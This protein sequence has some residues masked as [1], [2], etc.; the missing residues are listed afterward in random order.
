MASGPGPHRF[1]KGVSGNPGGRPKALKA[2]EEIARANTELAMDTQAEICR[3]KNAPAATRVS[4]AS[5]LL[6]RG[7]GKPKQDVKL[8]GNLDVRSL[9]DL[10]LDQAL[11]REDH[12][13]IMHICFAQAKQNNISYPVLVHKS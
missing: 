1:K 2:V 10:E 7:W 12:A 8:T 5:T 3:D 11:R 6:D 4:A 13:A 9:D